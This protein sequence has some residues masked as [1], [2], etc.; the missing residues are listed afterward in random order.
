MTFNVSHI[1]AYVL[2]QV[3][4]HT[5]SSPTWEIVT[6]YSQENLVNLWFYFAMAYIIVY[7]NGEQCICQDVIAKLTGNL[8][9]LIF[10]LF[11]SFFCDK[12]FSIQDCSLPFH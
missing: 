8:S 3:K 2:V 10:L 5:C 7:L 1:L 9:T 12:R 4:S 6:F 11:V